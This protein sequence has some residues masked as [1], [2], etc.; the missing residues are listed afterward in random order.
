M[1]RATV[2]HRARSIAHLPRDED[3]ALA[4]DPHPGKALVKADNRSARALRES[5]RL[6]RT[7]LGFAIVA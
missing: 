2:W 1:V 7:L 3:A 4:A 6:G 5:H